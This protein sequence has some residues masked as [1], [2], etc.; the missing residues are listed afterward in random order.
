MPK[1]GSSYNQ[2]LQEIAQ[3]RRQ[4]VQLEARLASG[5]AADEFSQACGGALRPVD[6]AVPDTGGEDALKALMAWIAHKLNNA[7]SGVSGNIV[8]LKMIH[9]HDEALT[10]YTDRMQSAADRLNRLATRLAAYAE[11]QPFD[12]RPISLDAFVDQNLPAWQNKLP[13][14]GTLELDLASNLPCVQADRLQFEL[15]MGCLLEQ[16]AT[17]LHPGDRLGLKFC[18]RQIEA[19]TAELRGCDPAGGHVCL[20]ISVLAAGPKVAGDGPPN[21]TYPSQRIS[22]RMNLAAAHHIIRKH[23][24]WLEFYSQRTT[25]TLAR[26]C[27]PAV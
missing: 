1:Q 23:G 12:P 5:P 21:P 26:C 11:G 3:L 14:G 4:V 9:P 20:T 15:A 6:E 19:Q 8:L 27:L 16:A 22:N 24:G 25:G 7:L 17:R 2:L 13:A 18:R 10:K